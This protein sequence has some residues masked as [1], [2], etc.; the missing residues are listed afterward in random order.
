MLE[1]L[2]AGPPRDAGGLIAS[3]GV[4]QH[5]LIPPVALAVGDGEGTSLHVGCQMDAEV[6]AGAE[7]SAPGLIVFP[8][9]LGR[10][11][12]AAATWTSL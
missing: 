2:Y 7:Q 10:C 12:R 4:R 1:G 5:V 6:P 11:M 3:H 8:V 9:C